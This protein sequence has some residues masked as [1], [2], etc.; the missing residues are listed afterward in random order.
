MTK[1]KYVF[2]DKDESTHFEGAGTLIFDKLGNREPFTFTRIVNNT[3][4]ITVDGDLD[5][6]G[7]FVLSASVDGFDRVE[8]GGRCYCTVGKLFSVEVFA[9]N[10]CELQSNS[11]SIVGIMGDYVNEA[12]KKKDLSLLDRALQVLED[13]EYIDKP[14]YANGRTAIM[15]RIDTAKAWIEKNPKK[16][17]AKSQ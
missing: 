1:Q 3:E 9:N 6:T 13:H 7:R 10:K 4:H 16:T 8:E 11:M 17:K 2:N 5:E 12:R 15:K 14:L